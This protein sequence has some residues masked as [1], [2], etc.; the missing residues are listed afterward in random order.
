MP[1]DNTNPDAESVA[2]YETAER[3][4]DKMMGEIHDLRQKGLIVTPSD[5]KAIM[6]YATDW[7]FRYYT[8]GKAW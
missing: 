6:D 2:M 8:D 5:A 4:M 1:N 7:I 3:L